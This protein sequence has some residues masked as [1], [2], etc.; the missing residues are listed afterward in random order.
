MWAGDTSLGVVAAS[1][2]AI[3]LA[4]VVEEAPAA[5][6]GPDV[7]TRAPYG[8]PLSLRASRFCLRCCMTNRN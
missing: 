8:A 5:A 7:T 6:A 3:V 1:G 2:A 4:V